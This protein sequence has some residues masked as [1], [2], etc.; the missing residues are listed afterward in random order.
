LLLEAC[1]MGL[2]R[3][4]PALLESIAG[5]VAE[6]GVFCSL[7]RAM[8]LLLVLHHSREPLEA[9][10]LRGINEVAATAYDRG[11]FVL[12]QLVN[13]SDQ[14]ES[15]NLDALNS[16]YQAVR[17]IGDTP[18]RQ[19]LRWNNLNA[20]A[21]SIGGNATMRGGASGLLF[22]EG[23]LDADRLASLLNGHLLS[24]AGGGSE[25]PKFLRGLLRTARYSL[26]Q[27]QEII[28]GVHG[29]LRQWDEDLFIR[30]LPQLRLAF[31]DLTPRECN[32][33]AAAVAD[34]TKSGRFHLVNR[35]DYSS[36]DMLRGVELNRRVVEALQ[37]DGLEEFSD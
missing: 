22:G 23:Q 30:Q 10:H 4:T 26:W 27:V 6:D 12:P 35:T 7:V 36:A 28:G 25:G 15:Q 8:E 14:E 2:H 21:S 5:L 37:R 29:V 9:H 13:T 20:L 16:L 3:Q 33:V 19:Q 34:L 1:R 32:Q 31:A 11:C 17:S 24:P 18:G